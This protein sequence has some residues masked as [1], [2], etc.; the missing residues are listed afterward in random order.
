MSTNR[1]VF[2]SLFTGS[3]FWIGQHGSFL[4]FS[5]SLLLF[6]TILYFFYVILKE[7]TGDV[8]DEE[9][10]TQILSSDMIYQEKY[11]SKQLKVTNAKGEGYG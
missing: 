8:R 9:F 6:F 7:S 3:F 2:L 1:K 5:C 4:K 11:G 10:S